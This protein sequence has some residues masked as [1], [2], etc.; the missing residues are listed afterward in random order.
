MSGLIKKLNL[1][2]RKRSLAYGILCCAAVGAFNSPESPATA[3]SLARGAGGLSV[4]TRL[5]QTKFLQGVP[6][7]VALNFTIKTPL[8]EITREAPATDFAIVLDTSGSMQEDRKL[9]FA[10][11]ALEQFLNMLRPQDNISMVSFNTYAN[12]DLHL[13]S[14]DGGAKERARSIVRNFTANGSTNMSEGLVKALQELKSGSAPRKKIVLLSD[15]Q[16][17]VGIMDPAGLAEIAKRAVAQEVV[18]STV[19]MGV[20]F[21]EVL[22]TNLAD[23]GMG[24]YA[25]LESTS[26]LDQ[27]LAR[28]ISSLRNLYAQ[29]SEVVVRVSSGVELIDASG[30]PMDRRA[31]GA[32]VIPTAGIVSGTERNFMLTF[33]VPTS[34]Q[35]T[36]TLGKIDF[37]AFPNGQAEQ[38]SIAD[39]AL[40]VVV[41]DKAKKEDVARSV[42]KELYRDSWLKNNVGRLKQDIRSDIA[43]GNSEGMEQKLKRMSDAAR[44]AEAQ[45]GVAI[46]Q[47]VKMAAD[48][49]KAAAAP[50]FSGPS[51][52]RARNQKKLSKSIHESAIK[53]QRK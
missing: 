7:E 41:V 23:H 2:A 40:E 20:D 17:N 32:I 21:N 8:S 42:D 50:A 39:K 13:T 47:D 30:Y 14:A 15:G 18:L 44:G 27:V 49:L 25:F 11:Q 16:A 33:K 9:G 10:K 53:D 4:Q 5:T 34:E 1:R 12:V 43:M 24:E 3:E 19:G 48:E 26:E 38:I 22:L 36:M 45:S 37:L 28:Y 31:D 52:E 35:R 6:S 51:E 29:R 46:E